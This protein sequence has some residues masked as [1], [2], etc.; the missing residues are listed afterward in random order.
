MSAKPDSN[1]LWGRFCAAEE[2]VSSKHCTFVLKFVLFEGEAHDVNNFA[3]F[4]TLKGIVRLNLAR[5]IN[6]PNLITDWAKLF[7]LLGK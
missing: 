4:E 2:D 7:V 5:C 6:T 3:P 1:L